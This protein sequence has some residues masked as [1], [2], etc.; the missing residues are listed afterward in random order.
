MAEY[1]MLQAHRGVSSEYPENTMAAFRAAAAQGYDVIEL[2]P[3]YT[4]DGEIVVLH[5]TTVNRTARLPGGAPIPEPLTI[6]SLTYEEALAYDYGCGFAPRFRGEKLPLLKDALELAQESGIIIK[7]DSKIE[8]FPEE[9]FRKLLDLLR[10]RQP[11]IALTSGSVERLQ[12][13]ARELPEAQLHYDG[14]VDEAV[15]E[16]LAPLGQR[17]TVWLPDRSPLTDWVR[18]PFAEGALCA[19][20]KRFARLGIWIIGD[21][22]SFDRV[23]RD[24]APDIVE[25]TGIIKPIRN[26]GL[27]CDTHVHSQNSHDSQCPV[28]RTAEAAVEKGIACFSITDH[29]D[30]QY[31]RE[32]PVKIWIAASVQEAE[33]AAKA[34]AGRVSV[35]TGIELGEAIW[36]PEGA[37]E[38]LSQHPYD[39]VIGSVHAVR[40]K[41]RRQAYS[42]IDFSAFPPE[43]LADYMEQYFEDVWEML[44]TIPCDIMA[45][46]TCPLRYINGKYGLQMDVHRFE[47]Q[48]RKILAY[49]IDHAI[50]LEINTSCLGS[51]YDSF[52]P[53]E[54]IVA[55]YREMGGYLVTLGSDAHAAENL[56]KGFSE[57]LALLRKYGFRNYYFY[58]DRIGIPCAV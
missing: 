7:I 2:D 39:V 8:R 52:M 28:E 6:A 15:L 17:L 46:L 9:M 45:H 38:M 42:R 13:Y 20:V 37:D 47:P 10:S 31:F 12:A 4:A 23:C 32:R 50:A 54:W 58:R 41:D 33:E 5:D 51:A 36:D 16:K 57:A 43:E 48:I 24:Y 22:V 49:I 21:E 1:P 53:E 30:I 26:R 14:P 34:F 44:Q 35:L 19:A 56:G 29:C 18:V 11:Q 27:L 3:N 40:Y 55:L 25:T